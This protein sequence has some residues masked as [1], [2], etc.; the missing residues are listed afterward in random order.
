MKVLITGG[1]GY[2]GSATVEVLRDAGHDVTVYDSLRWTDLY[3]EDVRFIRGDVR[4]RGMLSSAL[5]D[6]DAVVWLAALVGD[7]ACERNCEEAWQVNSDAVL[8]L[9]DNFYGRIV[10][11][12]TCSVYWRAEGLLDESAKCHAESVYGRTKMVAEH[13]LD[14]EDAVVFR[15]GTLFGI[16]GKHGRFRMDLVVNG[17]TV[18]AVMDRQITVHGG[19]QWRPHLHVLDAATAIKAGLVGRPGTYNLVGENMTIS[20]LAS[21]VAKAVPG[22]EI[23]LGPPP[24]N[25]PRDYQVS[26]EK[27][28][29]ALHWAPEQTVLYGIDEVRELAASGRL[30]DRDSRRLTN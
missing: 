1:A 23:L 20:D 10:F 25:D 26:G 2:L 15:L 7:A 29:K 18:K 8:W 21:A 19:A 27:A 11:P 14:G 6:Q 17:M 5:A 16:G 22:T 30:A 12:S 28:V 24:E 13:S 4:D 9:S 3:L